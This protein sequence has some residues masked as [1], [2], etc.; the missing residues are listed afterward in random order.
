MTVIRRKVVDPA[1]DEALSLLLL[2]MSELLGT[3][4]KP[5]LVVSSFAGRNLVCGETSPFALL[6]GQPDAADRAEPSAQLFL[7]E[8]VEEAFAQGRVVEP[9][10]RQF[11]GGQ[12]GA[13]KAA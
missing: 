1:L 2:T 8:A 6:G 12:S 5:A 9:A 10:E 13:E 7:R 11:T 3:Y 4:R